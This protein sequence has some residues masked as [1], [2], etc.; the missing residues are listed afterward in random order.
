LAAT[1]TILVV[2][3]DHTFR[4]AISR[5]LQ[6]AGYVII[7]AF[8]GRDALRLAKEHAPDLVL[9][10]VVLPDI[11]G[12]DICRQI[13]SDTSLRNVFV[14][15]ASRLSVSASDEAEGLES[16]ADSYIMLP[17]PNR[18]L[19]A[20]LAALLQLREAQISARA[21]I[22][23]MRVIA[24]LGERSFTGTDISTL[25]DYAVTSVADALGADHCD[26]FEHRF[27][28]NS[29]V[30]R[31]GTGLLRQYAGRIVDADACTELTDVLE[32]GGAVV[33]LDS[34]VRGNPLI[35]PLLQGQSMDARIAVVIP[36]PDCPFGILSAYA[37][38]PGIFSQDDA[39]F[40]RS[41]TYIIATTLEGS[42]KEGLA[43]HYGK[44][45]GRQRR[46]EDG[47]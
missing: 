33:H 39:Y 30:L 35:H 41:I 45:P 26:I 13:K 9:L 11:S 40:L 1:T 6:S 23:Q 15:I 31:A 42:T 43:R 36:G 25:M 32:S 16:G 12:M 4:Y 2:D 47:P 46:S 37:A 17:I 20:R 29:F 14:A 18:E 27:I 24:E 3:D 34:D 5:V 21:K 19:I 10:D 28:D 7:E 38:R 22:Q 8:T 44:Q